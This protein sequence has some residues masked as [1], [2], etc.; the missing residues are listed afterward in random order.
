MKK[1]GSQIDVKTPRITFL[2]LPA[3]S[4]FFVS[5]ISGCA[6]DAALKLAR[7][8]SAPTITYKEWGISGVTSAVKQKNGDIGVCL[9]LLEHNNANKTERHAI[10]L[11]VVSLLEEKTDL[12]TFGF[13]EIKVAG[14]CDG[15][16]TDRRIAEYLYPMPEAEKGCR[17]LESSKYP[18]DSILPIVEIVLP[19][20]DRSRLYSFLNELEAQGVSGEKLYEVKFLHPQKDAWDKTKDSRA[21]EYSDVLLVYRPSGM[22]QDIVA[23]FAIAGGYESEDESTNLFYLLVP[24][25]FALDAIVV[26]VILAAHRPM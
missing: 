11:P 10:Y 26:M 7:Q 21:A 19:V 6:T 1:N 9:E 20:K 24:P 16:S 17:K 3:L 23:P 2:L 5:L 18:A 25:A 14:H 15:A 12:E 4:L 13:S 22:G 8:K